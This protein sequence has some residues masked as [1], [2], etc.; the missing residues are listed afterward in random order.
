VIVEKK[1]I[2]TLT[3][4]TIFEYG[5]KIF[6]EKRIRFDMVVASPIPAVFGM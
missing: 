5:G 2:I 4:V 1:I 3:E 6:F